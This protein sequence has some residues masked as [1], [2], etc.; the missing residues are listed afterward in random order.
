[1]KL[2]ERQLL[3]RKYKKIGYDHEGAIKKVN[4]FDN[5]LKE[6]SKKMKSQNKSEKDIDK[7]FK[8][9]FEKLCMQVEAERLNRR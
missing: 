1:M 6:L 8:E 9:E 5:K 2:E 4:K 7:R 3:Y